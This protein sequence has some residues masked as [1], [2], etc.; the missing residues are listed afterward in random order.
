MKSTMAFGAALA[1]ALLSA[2]ASAAVVFDLS[3][4][5]LVDGGQLTGTLTTS[6]D[7][8]TLLGFSFTSTS[9]S[10]GYGSFTGRNYTL[11]DSL[12]AF[13]NPS[14]GL[15]SLFLGPLANVNLFF[16]AP[17]TLAGT[18][19]APSS[20]ETQIVSG[21]GSRWATSGEL[22]AQQPDVVPE[23]ASWALMVAG[24]GLV[25]IGLRRSAGLSRIV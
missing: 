4:V 25:G 6:D 18:S 10:S 9:N 2:P 12:L 7:L 23:P 24:F 11:G 14:V 17:L 8:S 21:G 15:S 20:S 16:S 5:Y 13:W 22:V 19:L 3:N 1:A